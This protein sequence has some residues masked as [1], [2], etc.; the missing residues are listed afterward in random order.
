MKRTLALVLLLAAAGSAQAELIAVTTDN[1][2]QAEAAWNFAN[3]AK[4][5]ADKEI[6]HYRDVAPVGP[7]AP[8]V[9]MNWDTLY[10]NRIVKVADDHIFTIKLPESDLYVS[11]H[12]V[13]ENGFAPYYI[14]EAGAHK[15]QVDTDYAWVLFRTEILDRRSE[16]ALKKAHAVQDQIVVEDVM[17]DSAYTAPDY[18]QEQLEALRK[19]YKQKAIESGKDYVY[20]ARAGEAD[21]HLLNMAHAAGWGGMPPELHVSNAYATSNNM[22]GDVCRAITFE[23]PKN[24]FFT[25]FTLYDAD[26]YLM[27]G[28]THINSKMW[29]L[30]AD[31]TVTLHF[32]CGEDAINN[33]S[34]GGR[35]F[36]YAIRNYGV[37]QKVLDGEFRPLKP[38]VVEE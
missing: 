2:A 24:K 1:F 3:W 5:G 27:E 37:S 14:V 28:E 22:S 38:E 35:T 4:L 19:K 30:N 21:Q 11:A 7:D 10:S 17:E 26:G 36:G 16:E 29:K 18:N 9:R 32:N 31:G 12:V 13:D 25:S 6:F 20:A 33:L 34:S 23:D 15:V 8:T